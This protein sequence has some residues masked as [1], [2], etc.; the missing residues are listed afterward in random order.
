M[1]LIAQYKG[2]GKSYG[3][4]TLF[5]DI[6]MNIH[7]GD[8]IGLIGTNGAGKSTLLKLFA[9]VSTPDAGEVVIKKGYRAVYLPQESQFEAGKTV[10]GLIDET[11]DAFC[12]EDAEAFGK[13][14]QL[15]GQVE[16]PDLSAQVQTLSGGW[17][18]RLA[19][20]L[21]LIKRP[22]LLF[23]DEPTNHLDLSGILW[24]ESLLKR[25]EFS[26]VMITH[27]RALL[28]N[29]TD[30]TVE[31]G[32]QYPGGY[33]RIE[34][35]YQ[36]FLRR[37]DE[38][39][40]SQLKQES[41]LATVMRRE[42]EWLARSPKARTTKAQFRIDNAK[43]M[44]EE[45]SDVRSRNRN[46]REMDLDFT[47]TQRK[48]RKLV[49]AKRLARHLEDRTLFDELS[50]V[51]S[52]GTCMGLVGNNGTGKSTLMRL[53]C[54]KDSPDGGTVREAEGLHIVHFE[55]ERDSLDPEMPLRKALSPDSD[56]VI[57]RG[58]PLHVVTWAKKFL[59]TPDQLDLPLGRLSGGEKARVLLAH[60]M[61]Q[62]ADVLLLDEPTND[63]DIPS[64]EMLE[65]SLQEF[66]GAVVLASHDRYLV[67]KISTSML[68]FLDAG[69]VFP[70]SS[71]DQWA[72]ENS[73]APVQ[74]KAAPEKRSK[75]AA[76]AKK[77]FTYKH[78]YELEQIEAKILEAEDKAALHEA[79]VNDSSIASDPAALQEACEVLGTVQKEVET[80]YSRWEELEELKA[81]DDIES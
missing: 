40:E 14:W 47:S 16:F 12:A 70:C 61:R 5:T 49:T 71:I 60:L 7:E 46:N 29:V 11:L 3:A 66:Q 75:Q 69:G 50:F 53:L 19:V 36:E 43:R 13:A 4:R 2:L 35:N 25:A 42:K 76:K 48:T 30:K 77:K 55:Q 72:R 23:L 10:S 45:L 81:A 6:S 73:P 18:K 78:K 38:L 20:V 41:A 80:L 58:R 37:R 21:A 27:D 64:L 79:R 33:L 67:E 22:D 57:Y 62:P 56:S 44:E 17:K 52:P 34:G 39:L 51:L 68:G 54:G 8:R 24:L 65:E 74:K 26:Y 28:S 15:I 1:S 59:F 63:L 32:T 9:E 31:L